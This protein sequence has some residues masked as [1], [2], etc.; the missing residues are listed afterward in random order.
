MRQR[1]WESPI[2]KVSLEKCLSYAMRSYLYLHREWSWV[3]WWKTMHQSMQRHRQMRFRDL[4]HQLPL[5]WIW[6]SKTLG[7]NFEYVNV[8]FWNRSTTSLKID[9]VLRSVATNV[10]ARGARPGNTQIC[11]ATRARGT[12]TEYGARAAQNMP[13]FVENP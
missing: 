2:H 5:V 8:S 11:T 1:S 9:L 6:V 13:G 10:T 12:C 4:D 3:H 7:I